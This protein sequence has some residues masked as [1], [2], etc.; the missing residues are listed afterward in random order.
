MPRGET[1]LCPT[2]AALPVHQKRSWRSETPA[3]GT[4][5]SMMQGPCAWADTWLGIMLRHM[6]G[7]KPG[8]VHSTTGSGLSYWQIPN[9]LLNLWHTVQNL[10]SRLLCLAN[11]LFSFHRAAH[12]GICELIWDEWDHIW[13]KTL[14]KHNMSIHISWQVKLTTGCR[15]NEMGKYNTTHSKTLQRISHSILKSKEN[16]LKGNISKEICYYQTHKMIFCIMFVQLIILLHSDP[17]QAT[18]NYTTCEFIQVWCEICGWVLVGYNTICLSIACWTHNLNKVICNW[19]TGMVWTALFKM[20]VY[21]CMC[22]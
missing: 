15:L 6:A 9:Q 22:V 3:Q 11:I 16:S 8:T 14:N 13:L 1:G 19:P 10:R 5:D 17:S 20:C 7:L 18:V 21:E 4:P 12:N 2:Y